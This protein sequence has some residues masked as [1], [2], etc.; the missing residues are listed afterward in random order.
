[1]FGIFSKNFL[2]DTFIYYLYLFGTTP[3][4]LIGSSAS[5]N[6]KFVYLLSNLKGKGC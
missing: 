5:K 6:W 3:I 2:P 1:L 4:T